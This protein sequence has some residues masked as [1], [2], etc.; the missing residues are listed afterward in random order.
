MSKNTTITTKIKH[1]EQTKHNNPK[2]TRPK[3]EQPKKDQQQKGTKK[4][5]ITMK[6]NK[7]H[8][9]KTSFFYQKKKP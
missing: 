3:I 4:E 7:H 8:L 2:K 5:Q 6:N 1:T 9:Y